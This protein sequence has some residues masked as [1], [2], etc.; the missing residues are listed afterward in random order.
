MGASCYANA[1]RV[2]AAPAA[3]P[4]VPLDPLDLLA[5]MRVGQKA[6]SKLSMDQKYALAMRVT[7]DSTRATRAV[8]YIDAAVRIYG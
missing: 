4:V 5:R 1:N 6:W 2:V 8:S 3:K 7:G